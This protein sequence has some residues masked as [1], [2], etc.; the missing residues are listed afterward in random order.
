MNAFSIIS[1]YKKIIVWNK[2]QNEHCL[3]KEWMN[4]IF[5]TWEDI[6][7]KMFTSIRFVLKQFHEK[8][9]CNCFWCYC[10]PWKIFSHFTDSLFSCFRRN[11]IDYDS[12]EDWKTGNFFS[13]EDNDDISSVEENLVQWHS[14][15]IWGF[16]CH[17]DFTSNQFW[18]I[19]E[20]QKLP[21]NNFRSS[22]IWFY[23][24]E[25]AYFKMSKIAKT[26][27]FRAA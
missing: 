16:F 3:C 13:G 14:G 11:D 5:K 12:G 6:S 25:I 15:E 26:S 17:S 1:F 24:V 2:L 10:L 8:Y 19:S 20:G 18:L 7:V 21:S 23:L 4:H 27:E 22:E 9:V